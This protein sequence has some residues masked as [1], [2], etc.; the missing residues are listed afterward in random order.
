LA[1]KVVTPF[2]RICQRPVTA[3]LKP[4]GLA[5]VREEPNGWVVVASSCQQ[6]GARADH[7]LEDERSIALSDLLTAASKLSGQAVDLV[8]VDMPLSRSPILRRRVSD[9]D[10]SAAY[11][12]EKCG[13]HSPSAIRPGPLSD[14][15]REG[16]ARAG[17]PLLTDNGASRGLIEVYPHPALVELAGAAER[18]P[19]K[20]SRH[21]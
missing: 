5:E 7:Q 21:R 20:A 18:L 13:T 9:N 16:F 19:Y 1:I 12:A 14:S 4:S 8:A 2:G 17:F 6:F 11:G 10:V 15:L 3:N